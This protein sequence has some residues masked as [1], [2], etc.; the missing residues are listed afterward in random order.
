MEIYVKKRI[1]TF[2]T[3]KAPTSEQQ[4]AE[5]SAWYSLAN[6]LNLEQ[7]NGKTFSLAMGALNTFSTFPTLK[8]IS[9]EAHRR[10]KFRHRTKL[11]EAPNGWFGVAWEAAA[12]L[13]YIL[14]RR[15]KL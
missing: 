1:A 7:M 13:P 11:K 9:C 10:V 2:E 5:S 6:I 4:L 12:L 3:K 8:T 14:S 15:D